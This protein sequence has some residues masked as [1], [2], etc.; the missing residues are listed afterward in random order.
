MK[1]IIRSNN[2]E[3]KSLN[4]QQVI[5]RGK[6]DSEFN[7]LL[8]KSFKL[9]PP[10]DNLRIISN[11]DFILA[12]L[13]FDQWNLI[14]CKEISELKLNKYIESLNKIKSV[15]AT[16]ISDAQIFFQITVKGSYQILNK[17]THFDFR[18]KSFK[19]MT[20]AQT[21]MARVNCTFFNLGDRLLISCNRSFEDY[22]KDRLI[23]AVNF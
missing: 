11:N 5:V 10:V 13:S 8:N 1:E 9:L 17:L 6:G 15:L 21:L 4:Y 3:I 2:V 20:V 12:K 14:Y 16:N 7:N 23:D 19:E 18:E 22:L